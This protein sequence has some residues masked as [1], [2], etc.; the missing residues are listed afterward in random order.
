MLLS[1][2]IWMTWS[3]LI[4]TEV[5]GCVTGLRPPSDCFVPSVVQSLAKP[6]AC[7]FPHLSTEVLCPFGVL[8]SVRGS[9]HTK[10]PANG[11]EAGCQRVQVCRLWAL[12]EVRG[13]RGARAHGARCGRR[14]FGREDN[15]IF[16]GQNGCTPPG[17]GKTELCWGTRSST[18]SLGTQLYL[19]KKRT[20]GREDSEIQTLGTQSDEDT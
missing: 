10:Q 1:S 18:P 14:K 2:E 7:S 19:R 13:M 16:K 12:G 11:S 6:G 20:Q 9:P 5:Q 4:L 17:G 8:S 15:G 3:T